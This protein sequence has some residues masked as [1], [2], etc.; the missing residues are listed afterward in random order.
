[1]GHAMHELRVPN[2]LVHLFFFTYRY[3]HVIHREYT[4]LTNAAKIRGFRPRTNMHTYRTFACLVG[5]LLVRSCERAQRVHHA[6]LCR[7]FK[8]AFHSLSGLSLKATD[9]ISLIVMLTLILAVAVLEWTRI[10]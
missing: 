2:K 7:G 4:R 8:G 6:M 10:T 9:T 1:L 3:I 5:M